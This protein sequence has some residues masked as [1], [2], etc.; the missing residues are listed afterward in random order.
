MRYRKVGG[1]HFLRV[2]RL[3]FSFCVCRSA[4]AEKPAHSRGR[5]IVIEAPYV[6]RYPG[7]STVVVYDDR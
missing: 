4:L 7:G 5:N 2:G 1:I 6:R 3:Q